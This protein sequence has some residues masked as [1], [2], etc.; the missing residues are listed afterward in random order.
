MSAISPQQRREFL[1]GISL[2]F[3]T[4]VMASTAVAAGKYISHDVHVSAIVLVQYSLSFLFSLPQVFRRGGAG[5]KTTRLKL[6]FWRGIFGFLCFFLFYSALVYLPLVDASLLRASAP[7]MVPLIVFLVWR[8]RL[9]KGQM[10]PLIVG[11]AGVFLVLRPGFD[12]INIWHLLAL[13]SGLGLAASMVTTRMLAL[14]EP[15]GRIV[16]YYCGI[17]VVCSLPLFI[18]N[19]Q[20]IPSATW[21]WLLYIGVAMYLSFAAYTRSYRYVSATALAPISYFGVVFA[22]LFDWLIWGHTPDLIT[23]AGIV[24]VSSGGVLVIR[25]GQ[26]QEQATAST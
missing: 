23:L 5:I 8:T 19:Y 24:L 9:R 25:S 22:G 20:P 15:E 2:S 13:A 14:H 6:H 10:L 1:I 4:I 7:L 17:S 21:G 26:A 18:A 3:I 12:D 11:F 16:F